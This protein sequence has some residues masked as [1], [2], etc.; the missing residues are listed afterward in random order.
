MPYTID[1][2]LDADIIMVTVS[3]ELDLQSLQDMAKSV[4]KL[5]EETG[6]K[7]VQN[8]LRDAT[9]AQLAIE[10]YHMPTIASDSGVEAQIQRA[11]VVGD[12]AS[13]F[14]FLETMFINR[15]HFVKM[16]ADARAAKAWL[17]G[18]DDAS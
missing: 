12:K 14:Y 8:D 13:E 7:R 4:A 15:G 17:I 9:A 3:G 5:V 2:D 6:C 18:G 11:L 10:I 1:Y 16:F